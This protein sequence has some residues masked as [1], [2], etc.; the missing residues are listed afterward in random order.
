M[1]NLTSPHGISDDC[2]I[3]FMIT[4][5]VKQRKLEC[6]EYMNKRDE[7]YDVPTFYTKFLKYD[8]S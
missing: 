2:D 3:T 4:M 5:I 7:L 6:I 8:P 1:I